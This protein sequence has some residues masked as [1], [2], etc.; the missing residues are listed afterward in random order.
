MFLVGIIPGPHEPKFDLESL[1]A[2]LNQSWKDGIKF[3]ANGASNAEIY[4][5]ALLCV[6]CDVPAARKVCGF[7]GHASCKGCS[8][9]TKAFPGTVSS[10]IDFLGSDPSPPRNNHSHNEQA[11]ETLNQITA[12]DKASVEQKYGTRYSELMLLP[13]FD[14]V[15][16]HIIDPMYNLFTGTAK[17]VMK[18]IWLD[19]ESP[20][21]NKNDL[22]NIQKK[23]DNIKAPSDVGRMPKKIVNTYGGFTADQWKS[24]TTF[25]SIYV[26]SSI[27]PEPDLTTL[28]LFCV[29]MLLHLFPCHYGNKSHA[30]PFLST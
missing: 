29:G 3:K 17:H 15:R 8:K 21:I 18:N 12:G 30:C 6:G 16:F 2:E 27:L 20:K 28:A 22:S 24:F 10:K 19:G 14:C 26:L 11:Q 1:V 25:F 7:T 5:A 23:L 4:H 13:Y 9:C